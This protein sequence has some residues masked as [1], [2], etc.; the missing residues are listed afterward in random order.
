[1]KYNVPRPVIPGRI[2][3]NQI[4]QPIW[5][6]F[7]CLVFAV[8][9]YFVVNEFFP[10]AMLDVKLAVAGAIALI[11]YLRRKYSSDILH[12]D[13][14]HEY[15]TA[16]TISNLKI[17]HAPLK[18][19]FILID[20]APK[21]QPGARTYRFRISLLSRDVQDSKIKIPLTLVESVFQPSHVKDWVESF[22]SKIIEP[23]DVIFASEQIKNDYIAGKFT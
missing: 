15:V 5:L 4:M 9:A 21:Y 23:L 12:V 14:T 3:S 2:Y 20:Q 8:L 10:N 19:Y 22:N 6:S 13:V 11:N 16:T 18:N 1:M 17:S 7:E